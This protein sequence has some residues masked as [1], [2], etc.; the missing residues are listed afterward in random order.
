MCEKQKL[1]IVL[2]RH[3]SGWPEWKKI[4]VLK[5]NEN[6]ASIT[7]DRTGKSSVGNTL[8]PTSLSLSQYSLLLS[9][10]LKALGTCDPKEKRPLEKVT[11]KVT[12]IKHARHTNTHP[13][14][15]AWRRMWLKKKENSPVIADVCLMARH[16]SDIT[17]YSETCDVRTP[18]LQLQTPPTWQCPLGEESHIFKV[19]NKIN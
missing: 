5:Q 4:S 2:D 12:K 6:F 15:D 17:M 3:V 1:T 10:G 9:V 19:K 7:C 8:H 18:F 13:S 14:C 11:T 16:Y